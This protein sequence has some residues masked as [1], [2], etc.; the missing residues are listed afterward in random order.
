MTGEWASWK[1]AKLKSS[2][3]I[4]VYLLVHCTVYSVLCL[5]GFLNIE[6][7]ILIC[8]NFYILKLILQNNFSH[9]TS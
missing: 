8:Q 3:R 1:T 2:T 7:W 6:F 5:Q 9:S 4:Q